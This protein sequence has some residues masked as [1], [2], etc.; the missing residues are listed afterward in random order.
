MRRVRLLLFPLILLWFCDNS[1]AQN[2]SGILDPSRAVNWS[3]AGVE[4]GI[5]NRTTNC[6]TS[7]CNSLFGGTVTAASINAALL[8]AP[9]NTVV[10]I[11][12][13]SY[14][15]SSG[16]AFKVDNVTLRG[17]GADQTKLT[18]SGGSSGCHIGFIEAA[19]LMCHNVANIGSDSPGH[20]ATWSGGYSVGT[21]S[22]TL[23]NVNG[24]AVGMCEVASSAC[25]NEGGGG[26]SRPNRAVVQAVKVTSIAGNVVTVSPPIQLPNFRSAQSPGAFWGDTSDYMKGSGLEDMSIDFTGVGQGGIMMVNILNSWVKGV[27]AVFN[28]GP[29]SFVDNIFLL[30]GFRVTIQDSYFVGPNV[31]G[32]TQY[33]FAPH[34]SSNFLYQNN[35]LQR[36]VSGMVPNDPVTGS[37]YAYNFVTNSYY[38]GPG[39]ILHNAGDMMNL[40]EG[41]NMSGFVGDVIHGTH[42]FGTLFR[43]HLDGQANN[44]TANY[45][46]STGLFTNNRF[47]NLI[48]NVMGDSH[49]NTYQTLQ[50]ASNASIY[51][52]GWRGDGSGVTVNNDANVNRTVMR[53]GNWDNVTSTNDT[54]TNDSTGTHFLSGEVP[55]GITNFENAVPASQTLPA[56]FYLNSKPSWFGSIPWPPIGPDVSGGNAP[57][58]SS[59]PTGGHANLIPARVCF[60]GLATDPAYGGGIK[61]FNAANC[62]A[63]GDP[64]PDPPGGLQAVPH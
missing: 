8:S 16:I 38:T 6:T 25:S 23:S 3:T 36:V 18:F 63:G 40:Y 54:G 39:V 64:P 24:L 61:V 60:K 28:S 45:N 46:F 33:V 10:R 49:W 34:V 13:G 15:L 55:S 56:S 59:F 51:V 31:Q 4:G 19:V 2:W 20:I 27:R 12:A 1:R 30:N 37:V 17:A 50:A 53:W 22:V 58:S 32:N 29:G 44:P 9:A 11:P 7:A 21:T 62:Y 47:Y 57:N 41:N 35:I 43:N 26:F 14:T 52:L 5:P 42:M 48:G